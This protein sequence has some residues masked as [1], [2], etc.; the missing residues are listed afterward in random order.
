MPAALRL[1]STPPNALPDEADCPVAVLAVEAAALVRAWYAL[2]DPEYH[3]VPP[4]APVPDLRGRYAEEGGPTN[5]AVLSEIT[6]RLHAIRDFA[7][8]RTARS[9]KGAAFQLYLAANTSVFIAGEL[10]TRDI[11]GPELAI[12][13]D[14]ERRAD[15]LLFSACAVIDNYADEDLAWLRA[16]FYSDH[17]K[18][19]QTMGKIVEELKRA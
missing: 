17:L 14:I 8:V 2:T 4:P 13:H 7:A 11:P 10:R 19:S 6:D 12:I 9:I 1:A 16:Y 15:K 5:S 18:P 3:D